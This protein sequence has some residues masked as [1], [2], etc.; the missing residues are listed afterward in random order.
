MRR[1]LWTVLGLVGAMLALIP[2]PTGADGQWLAGDLASWN[3]P[4][5]VIPATPGEASIGF[6][7]C[8]SVVRP[9]ETPEDAQVAGRGWLL[10]APYQ[11]GWDISV[12]QGTRGFD[13]NCRPVTYQLFVFVDGVFA[14]TL[15][16]EPMLSRADGALVDIGLGVDGVSAL[17]DRYTPSDG[18]CCPYEQTRVWFAVERTPAGPVVVPKQA[19][20]LPAPSGGR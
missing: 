11:L 7:Y 13:V 12:I 4:G 3:T 14:G 20:N 1:C 19:E 9:P 16:P 6:P 15:A 5:A 8:E 2:Q 18:L 10:L 17:Y